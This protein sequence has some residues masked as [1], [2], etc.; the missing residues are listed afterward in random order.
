MATRSKAVLIAF[1]CIMPASTQAQWVGAVRGWFSTPGCESDPALDLSD[2]AN[3]EHRE[4]GEQP[5]LADRV[6]EL[7][8]LLREGRARELA[9]ELEASLRPRNHLEYVCKDSTETGYV[10]RY[11]KNLEAQQE[12]DT[13][14]VELRY[15]L[16][17]LG[18][19][20]IRFDV[21]VDSEEEMFRYSY[22]LSNDSNATRPIN[23]WYIVANPDD[24]SM[25]VENSDKWTSHD[26][27][28]L[29]IW[30]PQPA[31]Y[32]NIHSP[33]LLNMERQGRLVVWESEQVVQPGES[34]GIFVIYSSLLPGWTTAYVRSTGP[35][36]PLPRYLEGIPDQVLEEIRY[37]KKWENRYS[38]IPIIGPR[39]HP[40]ID[41]I[42]VSHNWMNGI[43]IMIRHDWL[44]GDSPYV[45]E[46][47][48][49]LGDPSAGELS[50]R[51]QSKPMKGMEE[52]LDRIIRMAL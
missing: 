14:T 41:D 6:Q 49:F 26:P 19:P 46:L 15:E 13:E 34:T 40:R 52:L 5:K 44:N 2:R 9:Q 30:A 1:A 21:T 42:E 16:G 43:Q 29:P 18:R 51:I 37:L 47:I 33:E 24:L 25:Q 28:T 36:T 11:P 48:K 39:F 10:I 35:L 27:Y 23:R 20:K 7:T 31:L 50:S 8:Q 22:R 38:S 3:D 32:E 45:T 17:N 4:Y 12:S